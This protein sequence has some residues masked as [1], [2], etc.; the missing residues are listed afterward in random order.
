MSL[1]LEKFIEK[2]NEE[3]SIYSAGPAALLK[4]NIQ[5]LQPCFGRGDKFYLE[6]E[7]YVLDYLANRIQAEIHSKSFNGYKIGLVGTRQERAGSFISPVGE[8]IKYPAFSTIDMQLSYDNDGLCI[9]MSAQN[10][11]NSEIYDRG[12]VPLPGRW[13]KLG[14]RFHW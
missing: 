13:T 5:F 2:V 1:S 11:F 6:I 3:K 12:N 9:F 7:E 14:I 8:K 4:E 10:L